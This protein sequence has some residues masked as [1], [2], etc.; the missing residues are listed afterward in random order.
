MRSARPP[1]C[2]APQTP[3]TWDLARREAAGEE[4]RRDADRDE[5][6]RERR[7]RSQVVGVCGA[8]E[9]GGRA[10]RTDGHEKAVGGRC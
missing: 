3:T 7:A 2:S 4:E 10:E 9:A 6:E 5:R 8:E 1:A